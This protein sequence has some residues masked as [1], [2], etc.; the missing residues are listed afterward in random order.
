[1]E[2]LGQQVVA[3]LR[4]ERSL[5]DLSSDLINFRQELERHRSD[6]FLMLTNI[7]DF[8]VETERANWLASYSKIDDLFSKAEDDVRNHDALKELGANFSSYSDE[9]MMHSLALRE[10]AWVARGP[11]SHAG[12]NE[13]LYLAEQFLDDP[14]DDRH[15]LLQAKVDIEFLRLEHQAKALPE[16][17][18][19]AYAAMEEILPEYQGLLEGLAQIAELPEEEHEVLIQAFEEWAA[20]FAQYDIDFLQRRYSKV[21][22]LIPA[23]NFALNCQ[24]L[25]LEGLVNDEMVDHAVS[26]A[27]ETVEK[28]SEQFLEEKSLSVL[29]KH[30]YDE[31]ITRLLEEVQNL[32]EATEPSVL[33]EV[34]NELIGLVATFSDMQTKAED[35]GGSRLDFKSEAE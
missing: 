35:H 29:E 18:E 16:L 12:V 4:G 32:P 25:L 7:P 13:L 34:G 15:E 10:A 5:A 1:M 8:L 23:I 28:G 31:L 22:T 2:T 11:S 6:I 24:M 19:F 26:L 27:L 3:H 33:K 17:P 20:A 30:S 9:L 14:T 21:P